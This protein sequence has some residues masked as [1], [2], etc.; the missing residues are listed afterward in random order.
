[1][2]TRSTMNKK[3]RKTHIRLMVYVLMVMTLRAK[4]KPY[5]VV[6]YKR[7]GSLTFTISRFLFFVVIG[8]MQSRV[9]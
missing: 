1:M 6:K 3:I 2:D 8:Y 4:T 7:F 5:I 9:L